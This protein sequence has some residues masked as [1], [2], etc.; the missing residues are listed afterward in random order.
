MYRHVVLFKE[1]ITELEME[2]DH[3][4]NVALSHIEHHRLSGIVHL[5]GLDNVYDLSFFNEIRA[6][7]YGFSLI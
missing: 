4:I 1:N 7:E 3:Q 6:T 2:M 5:A